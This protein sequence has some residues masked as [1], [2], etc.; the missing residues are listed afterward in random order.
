MGEI[1]LPRDLEFFSY[2][3]KKRA[4]GQP[5]VLQVIVV[6]KLVSHQEYCGPVKWILINQLQL[7]NQVY[8][9]QNHNRSSE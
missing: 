1:S 5:F 8:Y 6:S 3:G 4:Y 7:I 2:F 9:L